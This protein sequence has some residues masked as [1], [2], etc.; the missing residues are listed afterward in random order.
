VKKIIGFLKEVKEEVSK[1]SWPSRD[2]VSRFTFVVIVA[3]AV[4]SVFLWVVDTALM[5]IVKLVMR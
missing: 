2:E 4:M 3:I 1:I 5:Q